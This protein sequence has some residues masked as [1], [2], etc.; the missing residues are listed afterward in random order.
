MLQITMSTSSLVL[1]V[2]WWLL[3]LLVI[4]GFVFFTNSWTH[5]RNNANGVNRRARRRMAHRMFG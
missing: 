5:A 1:F 2:C 4:L 3:L